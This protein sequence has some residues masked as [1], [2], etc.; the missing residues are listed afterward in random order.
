MGFMKPAIKII[1]FALL[2]NV[3]EFIMTRCKSG[4]DPGQNYKMIGAGDDRGKSVD[5][6]D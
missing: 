6:Q 5:D 3:V 4:N 2:Q 1:I